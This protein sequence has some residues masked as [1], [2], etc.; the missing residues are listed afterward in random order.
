M[1]TEKIKRIR[2]KQLYNTIKPKLEA[3]INKKLI[4]G[5]TPK[6]MN[7]FYEMY[8]KRKIQK[9]CE[10]DLINNETNNETLTK[11]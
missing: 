4:I 7:K 5:A 11:P 6:G 3:G 1:P 2:V 10:N 9:H 8:K